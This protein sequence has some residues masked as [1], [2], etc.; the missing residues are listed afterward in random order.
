MK[1]GNREKYLVKLG[2]G[3]LAVFLLLQVFVF[4][5]FE[6]RSRIRKGLAAKEQS[7]REI[8]KLRS[9]LEVL[10]K[11]SEDIRKSLSKR[12]PGFTLFSYLEEAANKADIKE[13][14][15]YMKP[16]SSSS[17]AGPFKE[18]SVEMRLDAITLQELI[19]YLHLIESPDELVNIK[20]LSIGQ[21]TKEKGYL[22]AIVQVVTFQ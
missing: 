2:A 16:S 22:D 3:C 7:L 20:R 13:R 19:Q 1:L 8:V 11:G 12:T 6:K 4:P 15:K 17:G 18:S 5:F 9:E 10:E 21:N 14:I